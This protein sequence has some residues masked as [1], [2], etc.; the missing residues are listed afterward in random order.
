MCSCRAPPSRSAPTP[1]RSCSRPRA[2][3]TC[4]ST[5]RPALDGG[6]WVICDRFADSTA[7]IRA[8]SATSIR[9]LIRGLERVTVGET[10]PDLT[11]ILDVPAEVGLARAR[12][13][14]GERRADRFEAETL[15]F[16]SK[17]REAYRELAERE[18]DRCVLIDATDD[19]RRRSPTRIWAVV[20]RRLDPAIGAAAS[21]KAARREPR[22]R[23]RRGRGRAAPARDDRCCSATRTP[24]RRCSKPIAAAASRMPG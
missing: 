23:G 4:A 14:R 11:F 9:A 1:R 17:L 2:T 5:I 24:S 22:R 16:H 3:I 7:S 12:E 15:E 13:R 10:K 19:A 18:P 21:S 6:R 8:C 20:E